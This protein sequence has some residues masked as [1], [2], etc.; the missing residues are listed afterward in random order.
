MPSPASDVSSLERRLPRQFVL[1]ADLKLVH[2]RNDV[3]RIDK[4]HRSSHVGLQPR[5]VSSG[6]NETVRKRNLISTRSRPVGDVG[7]KS[8][9]HG[10]YKR[11]IGGESGLVNRVGSTQAA[12]LVVRQVAETVAGPEH[13]AFP[14]VVG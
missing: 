7:V 1:D 4:A 9:A 2:A 3:T 8:G 14:E 6:S 11:C 13:Q 10:G 12:P 5:S